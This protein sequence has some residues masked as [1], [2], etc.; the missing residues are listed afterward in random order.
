MDRHT[1]VFNA[2]DGRCVRKIA[3]MHP[4]P[5]STMT[6]HAEIALPGIAVLS[7]P[8]RR[9]MAVVTSEFIVLYMTCY[10]VHKEVQAFIYQCVF[11]V[12]H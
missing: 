2:T 5:A 3:C 9:G 11:L 1:G 10:M 8:I 7:K 4:R 12:L 6:Q